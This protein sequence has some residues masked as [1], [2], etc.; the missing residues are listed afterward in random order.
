MTVAIF[1]ADDEEQKKAEET[2]IREN[3]RNAVV[4]DSHSL[5]NVSLFLGEKLVPYHKVFEGL[6]RDSS[7]AASERKRNGFYFGII[8]ELFLPD[9][10]V[11]KEEPSGILAALVARRN[12]IPVVICTSTEKA[13]TWGGKVAKELGFPLITDKSWDDAV[14]LLRNEMSEMK[15]HGGR[16]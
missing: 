15:K 14:R 8:T 10:S 6:E 2:V 7:P 1:D 4:E 16:R 9:S 5:E 3:S 11:T 12:N 13:A